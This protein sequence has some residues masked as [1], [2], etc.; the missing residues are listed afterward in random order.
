MRRQLLPSIV[1]ILL[2]TVVLG[3]VFPLVVLG[4][5]QV[6]FKDKADGSFVTVNGKRVGSSLIGQA[7]VDSKG[8]PIRKYF[9]SR[10]S[11]ALGVDGKTTAGYDPTL[12]SGSNLGPT[13]PTLIKLVAQRAKDYRAL[14][15]LAPNVKVP[16]DA[17]TASASGLDP[18][19]SVAN[20]RLQAARVARARGV[21]TATVLKMI[22][23]HT[24][25][26]PLGILG[27]KTV[28]VLDLNLALD[29]LKS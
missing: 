28:N 21:S 16:V 11:A 20:A 27:E 18:D 8:R 3:I 26:R 25:G 7:F 29:R 6:A 10:P 12:S 9:Q 15:G 17:V 19:I 13:N 24:D 4:I 2:F 22:D 1:A 5:G 14:N 23:Q